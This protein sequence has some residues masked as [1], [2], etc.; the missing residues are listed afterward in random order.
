MKCR[1]CGRRVWPWQ[2]TLGV[3]NRPV[4]WHCYSVSMHTLHVMFTQFIE[5]EKLVRCKKLLMKC[6]N[7]GEWLKENW[8]KSGLTVD[9]G[10]PLELVK[11]YSLEEE[12][13]VDALRTD[14]TNE[15]ERRKNGIVDGDG[16]VGLETGNEER[17]EDIYRLE[18]DN[19][20]RADDET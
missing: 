18:D 20:V 5:V 16:R 10:T 4:H 17:E 14:K 13:R 2:K 15:W 3:G 9:E 7:T 8:N 12:L 19:H 1:F 6:W 11:P